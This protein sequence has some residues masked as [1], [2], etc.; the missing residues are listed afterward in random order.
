MNQQTARYVIFHYNQ[1]M[2]AN[3]REAWGHLIAT[4]KAE[5]YRDA[6]SLSEELRRTM[7][8]HFSECFSTDRRFCDS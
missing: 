5:L 4:G 7:M 3:E 2:N 8:Q 6:T 1:F